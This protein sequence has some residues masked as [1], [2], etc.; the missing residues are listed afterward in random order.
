MNFVQMTD[1]YPDNN[2]DKVSEY[3][4]ISYHS[5]LEFQLSHAVRKRAVDLI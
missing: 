1:N 3:S 2:S 5:S 4:Y